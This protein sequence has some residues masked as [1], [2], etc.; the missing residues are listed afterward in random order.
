MVASWSFQ[1]GGLSRDANEHVTAVPI[2]VCE[3][4]TQMQVSCR[5]DGMDVLAVKNATAFAKE[6]SLK[7]GPIVL[8]MVQWPST[9]KL[10][11]RCCPLCWRPCASELSI[12][13]RGARLNPKTLVL[14]P[15]H[16][17]Q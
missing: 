5:V 13:H 16:M 2:A 4:S 10:Q 9:S 15:F 8:E 17:K 1:P 7:N 12:S 11:L 14:N 6:F 3:C